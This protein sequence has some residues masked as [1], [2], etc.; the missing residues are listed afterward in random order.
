MTWEHLH[1]AI[2]AALNG[3]CAV[4]LVMGRIA[5]ARRDQGGHRKLMLAAFATSTI[6]LISYLIRFATTGAHKY[7]GDGW[8]KVAYLIILFSHM[9]LAVVLVPI[10]L[11][12]LTLALRGDFAKH[13]RVVKWAWPIWMYVS[14]TGVIVYLMLYHLG[15]ALS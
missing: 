9:V 10:V 6:F 12:A 2:N 11:R 3:T 8:D 1:P 7:P 4:L 15:P 13:L 5:I 14:A